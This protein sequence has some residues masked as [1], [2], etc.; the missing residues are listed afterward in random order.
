[1]CT[2]S[3]SRR[4]MRLLPK[5]LDRGVQAR[6][7]VPCAPSAGGRL[8]NLGHQPALHGVHQQIEP[9]P[10]NL[11][12]GVARLRRVGR[13]GQPGRLRE[14]RVH[15]GVFKCAGVAT[16]PRPGAPG[17][18]VG[19]VVA[20]VGHAQIGIQ[21]HQGA[22]RLDETGNVDRLAV[23]SAQIHRRRRSRGGHAQR[24]GHVRLSWAAGAAASM[25]ALQQL[26]CQHGG[27]TSGGPLVQLTVPPPVHSGKAGHRSGAPPPR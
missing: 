7:V 15:R 26:K 22:V 19:Q 24:R 21:R 2:A 25:Q 9:A 11:D 3:C 10:A 1:M 16:S 14:Q 23:A 6:P 12:D 13:R 5:A 18:R 8:S 27:G 20:G 17:S 4:N